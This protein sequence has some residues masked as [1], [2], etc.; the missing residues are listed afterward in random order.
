MMVWELW[1]KEELC[2]KVV[3]VRRK[4]GRVMTVVMTR[5]EEVVRIL[6]MAHKVAERVHR[7]SIFMMM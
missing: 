1:R 5:E 6:C 4:S 2:E 7:K 3:Q